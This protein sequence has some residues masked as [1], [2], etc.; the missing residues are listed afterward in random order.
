MIKQHS[1]VE[2]SIFLVI[3]HNKANL[4]FLGSRR[5]RTYEFATVIYLN[6]T[7][8]DF[9]MSLVK[10][11]L[12]FLQPLLFLVD[13]T[14]PARRHSIREL[15]FFEQLEINVSLGGRQSNIGSTHRSSAFT[16]ILCSLPRKG[17]K[18]DMLYLRGLGNQRCI[19]NRLPP[20]NRG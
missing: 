12:G 9:T 19:F 11:L 1:L 3:S 5:S 4:R 10:R 17:F 16:S 18:W 6:L 13:L 15:S 14:V 20:K 8:H 2:R 7:L